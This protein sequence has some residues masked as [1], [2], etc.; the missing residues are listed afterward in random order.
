MGEE[1][2]MSCFKTLYQNLIART[3]K[4]TK[5]P[6]KRVLRLGFAPTIFQAQSRDV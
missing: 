6:G 4:T 5:Y 1:V 3:G 2:I